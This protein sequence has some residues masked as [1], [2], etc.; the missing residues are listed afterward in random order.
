MTAS[1]SQEP[2]YD[3]ASL[4]GIGVAWIPGSDKRLKAVGCGYN[5]ERGNAARIATTIISAFS[6]DI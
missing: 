4:G 5:A 6:S 1:T 3:W 2:P